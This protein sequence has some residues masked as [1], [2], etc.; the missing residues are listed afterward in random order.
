MNLV[1]N[2]MRHERA[3]SEVVDVPASFVAFCTWMGV[4]LSPAQ[5]TLARIAFDG[6]APVN[7][8]A[9]IATSLFG[10]KYQ[11][12]RPRVV[13]AVCGRRAGK[14]YILVALRLLHGMLVRQIPVLPPGARAVALIIAPRDSLRMEVFR[15][16][17]GALMNKPELAS[18]LVGRAK[19][20]SFVIKRP[21]GQLIAF[22]TGVATAGGTAARG[23][24]FTDLALDE[25]AFFRDDSFKV[26]DEELFR[27]GSATLLPGGQALITSTPWGEA[28]LLYRMW[29]ARPEGTLVAHAPTLLLNDSPETR[30]AVK[31]AY[32][33]DPDNAKREF[34]AEFMTGGTTVFF[35]SSTI[36]AAETDEPFIVQ[37]H[38]VIA[39]GGDFGFRSDSSALIL[40]AQR[41]RELHVFD[42]EEKRP[43]AGIPL[44]PSVT[45]KSFAA[46]IAGR[47]SYLMADGHY[48][49]AIAEHLEE[50]SLSYAPAPTSP[51][52]TYVRARMLLREARVLIHP[53]PFR[54]RLTQQMREVHGKPTSGGGMSIHH[55]R[56]AQGGHGDLV[57]ALV[58][59][60]W[61]VSGDTVPGAPVTVENAAKAA[62]AQR[63]RD[64][65]QAPRRSHATGGSVDAQGKHPHR[66]MQS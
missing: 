21:D 55:P 32:L 35:E 17:L 57:A 5:A 34:G 11:V 1:K 40:V 12:G 18:M 56:W 25:C 24:W 23:R 26:N 7:D 47:C 4:T 43:C 14:S 49:E 60:L 52:E 66:R 38:D 15:Y 19:V 61:Q 46:C 37:P 41:G 3:K 6:E 50:S 39:A 48:R 51:A 30:E 29:K 65:A 54:E 27:A 22:E 9:D 10:D 13:A 64:E 31:H 63:F 45:V 28:G 20:D 2:L 44:R 62:R 36:D 16:A 58:L 33:Q 53:L 8:C 59:A 42:G